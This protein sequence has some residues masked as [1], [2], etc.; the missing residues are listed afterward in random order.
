MLEAIFVALSAAPQ[1]PTDLTS[2]FAVPEG[3]RVTRFAESPQL[4][5]PTA[6]DIDDRNRV[7][8]AEGVNYRK[9]GG[10]NPG[11]EH[12]DGERIVILEDA[13]G[14][15]I[16]ESSKVFVEDPDLLVPLGIAVIGDA[17]YVSCSPSLIR[18]R[19]TDG[20]DRA[21][22]KT[23]LLTGF[24]GR[25][26]DHGLHSVVA[27]P[28]GRLWFNAGNEGPHTV[29]DRDGFTLR[30][31]R[32]S[33]DGRTWVQGVVLRVDEDGGGLAP[34]AH[35][36][37]NPYEVAIDAFGDLWQSDNDD[38]GN[39]C[40]RTLWVMPGGDHG[41]TGDD[42]RRN[43]RRDL[44]GDQDVWAAHWHQDDPGVVPAGHR[45]GAG[46]PTGVCV[47][48]EGLLPPRFRGAVLNADAG[49][50]VVYVHHP[51]ADGSGFGF[52]VETLISARADGDGRPA[53]W[54]RPSD[55]AVGADGAIYVADWYDP[56]VGGHGAGDREAYGRVLRIAPEGR[57]S[58]SITPAD[59]LAAL[60]APSVHARHAAWRW[61]RE[62]DAADALS[63]LTDAWSS[64]SDAIRRARL[65]WL[66]AAVEGGRALVE[67]AM[68]SAK[69]P[70]LR[71]AAARAL[72]AAGS[73]VV[74]LAA[75]MAAD[76]EPA[77]RR[78]AALMLR[79]VAW[80]DDHDVLLA[81]ARAH[82]AGDRFGLE[83]LGLAAEGA[84]EQLFAALLAERGETP[85]SWGPAFAEVAWRLHPTSAVQAFLA[86]ALAA[87][88]TEAEQLAAVS[89]LASVRDARA[90]EAVLTITEAA[91]S[92][93]VRAHAV[94]WLG[95]RVEGDWS[96]DRLRARLGAMSRDGAEQAYSSGVLRR[97]ALESFDIDVTGARRVWLIAQDGGDGYSHDWATWGEVELVGDDGAAPLADLGWVRATTGWGQVRKNQN[98]GGGPL[99]V[100]GREFAHGIGTHAVS[101]IVFR[102][103]DG[104]RRLRGYVG[105]DDGGTEQS[106]SA[107][108]VSFEIWVERPE[109]RSAFLADRALVADATQPVER[110]AEAAARLVGDPEGA[111]ALVGMQREGQ[112]PVPIRDAVAEPLRR[113]ADLGV[114]V[115]AARAFARE[116]SAV[117]RFAP[118]EELAGREG[119]AARGREVF[120]GAKSACAACHRYGDEGR[121]LGPELTRIREKL[122]A[123]GLLANILDPSAAIAFGYETWWIEKTDGTSLFGFLLAD[124]PTLVLKDAGGAT[125]VVPATDV[126]K[127]TAQPVSLMPD[128]I[129]LGL[130]EQ[131][132]VD[133][134]R[135]LLEPPR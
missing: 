83:A 26:H 124:G 3:M 30:T 101:E 85:T 5:N 93:R 80:E 72:A 73:D 122:D 113:H 68:E 131:E 10:R 1:E 109:D 38:D 60:H 41:Y 52:E 97:G 103:P 91:P 118:I 126:R 33:D 18:Y 114:R 84:E 20:D 8:V 123:R 82:V 24:G 7:W 44:R 63:R 119:D 100:R 47:Y 55:V 49:R 125:H 13:D 66:L 58:G 94:A 16:A 132:L 48:E 134:V 45:N 39:A 57:A 32:V 115:L 61:A 2:R 40:C 4:Y 46:G 76:P 29:T 92:E 112:L 75:A 50:G 27:G 53:R 130:E 128:T 77:V 110:R 95:R 86:R 133:L 65:T 129:A 35:N 17:V 102:L 107:S 21:D 6:I 37:R 111:L 34:I 14:D 67:E 64:E 23:I 31:G 116:G 54:F 121:D 98:C 70:R 71:I 9:G 25:D 56:N 81:L 135:F 78:E 104:V 79:D 74:A 117:L 28:D 43:W 51:K 99:R 19:D 105:P 108:S 36:F 15:G 22:Q 59:P 120:F 62:T 88:L 89:A 42:G 106:G 87:E 90:A 69:E 11:R 127:R 12:P 96:D